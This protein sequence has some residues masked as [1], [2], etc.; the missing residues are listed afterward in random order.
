MTAVLILTEPKDFHAFAV[1]EALRRQ[2]SEAVLWHG[3]DFPG[4]QRAS[5]WCGGGRDGLEVRGGGVELRDGGFDAVWNRRPTEAV[6]P[7]GLHH[8]DRAL[9]QRECRHFVWSLWHLVAPGAFWVNPLAPTP[10]AT[11]KPWQLR[12]AAEAGLEIPE[13]LCS[14]DP[15]RIADFLRAHPG[16]A[17]FKS[18]HPGTWRTPEGVAMLF[19]S[20]VTEA[21]LPTAATLQAAPGI[22]QVRV[23]KD[24]ELRVTFFGDRPVAARLLSQ[25]D[26]AGRAD[27]RRSFSRLAVEPGRLPAAIARRCRV[28]MERLGIVFGCFDF[29]VT[30]QGRYVFLELNSMGQFLFLEEHCPSL[31]LLDRFCRFI[32]GEGEGAARRRP[33]VRL[34]EVWEV[35]A[36]AFRAA[37]GAHVL[38][39]KPLDADEAQPSRP[40]RQRNPRPPREALTERR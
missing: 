18:F 38:K 5:V 12:L 22:F 24:H 27:W 29:I 17:V 33:S 6:L 4:R 32:A 40:A 13:T 8:A 21:D 11:L 2:G 25:R 34:G 10:S 16:E 31:R 14:N 37:P 30:P 39:P 20:P 3:P 1:A 28:L 15:E 9:A 19:T 36:A 35:A 23:A 7:N 26:S